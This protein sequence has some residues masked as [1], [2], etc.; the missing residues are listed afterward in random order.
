MDSANNIYVADSNSSAI[1]KITLTGSDGSIGVVTTLA[2]LGGYSGF[3]DGVGSGARFSGPNGIAV[4]SAGPCTSPTPETMSSARSRN[5]G[6]LDLAGS[7]VNSGSIDGPARMHV[8]R[9]DGL[10]VDATAMST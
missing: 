3:L 10:A 1:R 9:A 6:G 7:S 8:L 4:D 5:P 2:G